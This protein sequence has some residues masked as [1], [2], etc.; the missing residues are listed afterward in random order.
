MQ[1]IRQ[2]NMHSGGLLYFPLGGRWWGYGHNF[3]FN[4]CSCHVL[5][6]FSHI[7]NDVPSSSQ[8]VPKGVPYITT[9]F[10]HMVTQKFFASRLYSYTEEEAWHFHLETFILRAPKAFF[11]FCFW[12]WANQNSSLQ[13]K[14]TNQK[15]ITTWEAIKQPH[16]VNRS[17]NRYTQLI[18]TDNT[19]KKEILMFCN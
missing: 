1:P 10:S 16:L 8:S 2:L 9:F 6:V 11:F 15:K 19:H 13:N 18:I 7:P 3:F 5:N 17:D 12:W 4:L 14:Q